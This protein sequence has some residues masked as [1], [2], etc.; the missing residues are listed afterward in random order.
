MAQELPPGFTLDDDPAALPPGFTLDQPS[1]HAAAGRALSGQGQPTAMQQRIRGFNIGA[2]GLGAG[3]AEFVSTPLDWTNAVLNLGLAGVDKASQAVGG[4]AIDYRLKMPSEIVKYASGEAAKAAGLPVIDR[5]DMTPLE[6]FGYNANR[7]GV[8][9]LGGGALLAASAPARLLTQGATTFAA[10]AAIPTTLL[11]GAQQALTNAPRLAL[12]AMAKPYSGG[13]ISTTVAGDVAGGLG[14][15]ALITGVEEAAK[16]GIPGM[17]TPIA[18]ALA[19]MVG[20][21]GGATAAATARGAARTATNVGQKLV[22]YK[23]QLPDGTWVSPE[24]ARR[25]GEVLYNEALDPQ[26]AVQTARGNLD[27]LG[28][29]GMR[30]VPQTGDVSQDPG[31][32]VLQQQSALRPNSGNQAKVIEHGQSLQSDVRNR[33][34]EIAPNASPEA[35]K[36][37]AAQEQEARLRPVIESAEQADQAIAQTVAQRE[38]DAARIAEQRAQEAANVTQYRGQQTP[39]SVEMSDTFQRTRDAAEGRQS[40]AFEHPVLKNADV[41]PDIMLNAAAKIRA[42]DSDAAPLHPTVRKWVDRYKEAMLDKE[43]NAIAG[44]GFER[45]G[46]LKMRDI[47]ANRA[48]LNSD[49]ASVVGNKTAKDQLIDLKKATGDYNTELIQRGGQEG[50]LAAE[51]QRIHAQEIAQNFRGQTTGGGLRTNPALPSE[52]GGRFAATPES[53]ADLNR[54]ARLGGRADETAN[55]MRS[56]MM[57]EFQ[58]TGVASNGVLNPQLAHKWRETNAARIAEVPGLRQQVDQ[59]VAAAEAGHQVGTAAQRDLRDATTQQAATAQAGQR[60]VRTAQE[61]FNH[62]AF[63]AIV[64]ADPK[65]AI[66]A[67]LAGHP[68]NQKARLD[69]LIRLTDGNKP[70]REGLRAAIRE[71]VLEKATGPAVEKMLPGDTRRPVSRAKLSDILSDHEQALAAIHTHE[72]MRGMRAAAKTLDLIQEKRVLGSSPTA[73]RIMFDRLMESPLGKG[74][75]G[76]LRFKYGVLKVGGIRATTRRILAGIGENQRAEIEKLVDN[77]VRNPELAIHLTKQHEI[78]SPTWNKKLSRL[79]NISEGIREEYESEDSR[80]RGQMRGSG[81]P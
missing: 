74:V 47:L 69:E 55:A 1:P 8:Q 52:I 15:G 54:I 32:A 16:A 56:W 45:G 18:Q 4:P 27:E 73:E 80:Q 29:G 76:F 67:A 51:A 12:H 7:I 9:A 23:I 72:E 49:I 70:A 57:D 35:L 42:L 21:I 25:S 48:E 22:G 6:A 31:W 63:G 2:Q 40:A 39:A 79:I 65:H 38:A 11:G 30:V 68:Y 28:G 10:P 53:L 62:S 78:G 34:D 43:G 66:E 5:A 50:A 36:L 20:G 3:T 59:V 14:A 17:D 44:T 75:E 24:S 64:K 13:S 33:I 41:T 46:P 60:A 61:E 71:Y 37:R 81:A 77:A 19:G 58:R 26:R